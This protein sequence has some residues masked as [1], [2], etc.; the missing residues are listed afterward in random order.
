MSETTQAKS[1]GNIFWRISKK[2][3]FAADT[4]IPDSFVFCIILAFVVFFASWIVEKSNPMDLIQYWYNGF[5]TQNAFAFQMTIMVVVCA[6]F[7]QSPAVRKGLDAFAGIAKSPYVAMVIF[8]VF[9]YVT[10][11]INWAFCSIACPVLAM[12]MAK[13]V[14]GLHFPMMMAAGYS[15]MVLGQCMG[16]SA[17]LYAR[18]AAL[19]PS[20][21]E[22]PFFQEAGWAT[23]SISQ[24]QTTY[25]P[26]NVCLWIILA[27]V[28]IIV[29]IL[30]VPPKEEIVEFHAPINDDDI[31]VE[32]STGKLTPAEKMNGSHILMW[33]TAIVGLIYIFW[34][35]ATKGILNS[36]GLNFM[37]FIFITVDCIVYNTPKKFAA[38]IKDSMYLASD[39]MIQFPFYGAIMGIMTDS[40]LAATIVAALASVATA[41]SVPVIAYVSACIV[42]LFIPSQGGQW[43]VQG[44][45]MLPLAKQFGNYYPDILNAFVYGDEATNLLQPLYLIPAL[46]VVN[47]KLKEVW[48]YCAYLFVIWFIITCIGL[49]ILPG[50]M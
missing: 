19:D 47:M 29:S 4:I 6:A 2:F 49:Y 22:V 48:G 43:I 27:V 46:A 24:S 44:P 28:T 38:A 9:G 21:F 50:I 34:S 8:M 17:S 30:T 33:M 45:I 10:S 26:M 37:I 12:R 32:E 25:N 14:K 40:G 36:L 20:Y 35:F 39:V 3:Q 41:K 15:T 42:N 18:V 5:W 23:G 31:V 13:K 11:F 1:K 7:A 16:P